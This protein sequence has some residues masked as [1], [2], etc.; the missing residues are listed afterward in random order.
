MSTIK[1]VIGSVAAVADTATAVVNT[2]YQLAQNK[3]YDPYSLL[4]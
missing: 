3:P 2:G 4:H 1:S